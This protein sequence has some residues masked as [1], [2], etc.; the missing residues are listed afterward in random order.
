[1]IL[2]RWFHKAK[3]FV[4]KNKFLL[5]SVWAGKW[6]LTFALVWV[7]CVDSNTVPKPKAYHKIDFQPHSY[8]AH[9]AQNCPFIFEK[10]VYANVVQ[11]S[12]FFNEKVSNPC[13]LD[14][15]FPNYNGVLHLSYKPIKDEK[16]FAQFVDD[17][18]HLTFKHTTRAESIDESRI[19]TNNNVGGILYE[20]GGDAASN[21]QFFLTDTAN[22]F[23]R[24]ALYFGN[25]PNADS[26]AP[27]V[28]YVKEDMFHLIESFRW[29]G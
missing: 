9:Q 1:M 23:I 26:I 27:V 29:K 7:G 13:W 20:V 10:P 22:H 11:D 8:E 15:K 17:A 6:L 19:N 16:E 25:T 21:V 28:K 2:L 5:V 24:G 3:A 18:H 4:S 14:L 12:L